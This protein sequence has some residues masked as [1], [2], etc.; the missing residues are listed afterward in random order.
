MTLQRLLIPL[1]F[2]V[3]TAALRQKKSFAQLRR[4]RTI[5]S[6]LNILEQNT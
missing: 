4:H 2:S 5:L 1:P 6:T 3:N